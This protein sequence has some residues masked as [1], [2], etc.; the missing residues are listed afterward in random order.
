MVDLDVVVVNYKTPEDLQTFCESLR[1]YAEDVSYRVFIMDVCPEGFV[2]YGGA[3]IQSFK[4]NVGYGHAANV[5]ANLG[6]APLI[7]IFNADVSFLPHQLGNIVR[8]MKQHENWAIVGPR[9]IDSRGRI[10][11]AGFIGSNKAPVHRA[12]KEPAEDKWQDAIACTYVMGSAFFIR[13]EVWNELTQCEKN[14]ATGAFLETPLYF[15]ETWC[16]YHAREHGHRVI[17]YGGATLKHEWHQA[18]A[19]TTSAYDENNKMRRAEAMFGL[20]CDA[21]GIE[22]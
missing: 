4:E 12:W 21:H 18:I 1:M 15:E 20:A 22:H 8:A 9:Q 11:H 16:C 7:G 5:G 3:T 13:R 14:P 6:D 10:M 19:A 2:L 17:Y